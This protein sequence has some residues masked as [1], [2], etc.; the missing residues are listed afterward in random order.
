MKEERIFCKNMFYIRKT[1]NLSQKE[2]AKL[3]GISVYA[4]R[5]IEK[6]DCTRSSSTVAL[7]NLCKAINILPSEILKPWYKEQS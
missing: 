5:I 4:L 6:G 3:C 1:L 7:V 2:M